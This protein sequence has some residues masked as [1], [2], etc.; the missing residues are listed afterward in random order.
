MLK[1]I[2]GQLIA[3]C[4]YLKGL[5]EENFSSLLEAY[6]YFIPIC[7]KDSVGPLVRDIMKTSN[8]DKMKNIIHSI[9]IHF[10]C[11]PF[12]DMQLKE[13]DPLYGYN[14]IIDFSF[15]SSTE[16]RDSLGII[17]DEVG[18]PQSC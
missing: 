6:K 5:K 16:N 1:M 14:H 8:L 2:F 12:I 17:N 18:D 4:D 7:G 15:S 11:H 9:G 13:Q 3:Y 10:Q